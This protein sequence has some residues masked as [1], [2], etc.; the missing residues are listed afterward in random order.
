M[1]LTDVYEVVRVSHRVV[2]FD[3]VSYSCNLRSGFQEVNDG[4]VSCLGNGV[5]LIVDEN[6][7]FK[8]K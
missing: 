4:V 2:D 8:R 1:K 5:V 6:C 3:D 7:K